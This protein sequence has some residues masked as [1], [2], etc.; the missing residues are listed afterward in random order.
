MNAL[1]TVT[2]VN[3][4]A[5]GLALLCFPS[6]TVGAPLEAPAALI[7]AR[8]G[9]PAWGTDRDDNH[10]GKTIPLFALK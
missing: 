6:T 8:A 5:A 9:D 10:I 2:A 4:I 1:H 3:E 7:V